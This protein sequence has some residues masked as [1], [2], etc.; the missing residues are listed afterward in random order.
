MLCWILASK[1]LGF[2]DW[3]TASQ[4]LSSF[5]FLFPLAIHPT[6]V[7]VNWVCSYAWSLPCHCRPFFN[8][9]FGQDLYS[10]WPVTWPST[11]QHCFLLIHLGWISLF[12]VSSK[13]LPPFLAGPALYPLKWL[14]SSY[15]HD[16]LPLPCPLVIWSCSINWQVRHLVHHC[17]H[18]HTRHMI[19][20]KKKGVIQ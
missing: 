10:H 1:L 13:T 17:V 9:V 11:M 19:M 18:K 7:G 2:M 14:S 3:H 4:S 6:F 5:A 16:T 15:W 8:D 20:I 12:S